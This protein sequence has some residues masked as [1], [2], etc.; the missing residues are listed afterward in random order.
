MR[1]TAVHQTSRGGHLGET[2]RVC[3]E[4]LGIGSVNRKRLAY[5]FIIDFSAHQPRDAGAARQRGR[6]RAARWARRAAPPGW[7]G[8]GRRRGDR[9]GV[10]ASYRTYP[11]VSYLPSHSLRTRRVTRAYCLL[12]Y[13]KP[14]MPS[15]PMHGFS[16]EE[17]FCVTLSNQPCKSSHVTCAYL[18]SVSIDVAE[19]IDRAHQNPR[20]LCCPCRSTPPIRLE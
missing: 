7:P 19:A 1:A 13:L 3:R 20:T 6:R 15:I 16:G 8:G 17:P 5:N 10:S 2:E 11:I 9:R 12:E 18:Y 14:C 4:I